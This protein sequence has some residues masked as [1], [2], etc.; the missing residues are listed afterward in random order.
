M[1]QDGTM[2]EQKDWLGR[3]WAFPVRIDPQTGSM[4]MAAYEADVKQSI[5]ILIGTKRGERVRRADFGCGVHDLV[6]DV[7]DTALLTRVE[8]E[9]SETLLRYE[10]RIEVIS[11]RADPIHAADGT[12]LVEIEYRVRRTNQ[13]GNMVFP[14]YFREGGAVFDEGRR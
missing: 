1:Q 7:I 11:V 10:A 2:Q 6:F 8:V 12:L 9:V 4:A 13:T 5:R 14:F 3:G